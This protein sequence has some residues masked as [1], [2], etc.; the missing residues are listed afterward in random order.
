MRILITNDDGINAPGLKVLEDIAG[1]LSDDVWTVAPESDQSGL[2]HS[3]TL[4]EPLRLRALS[5][6]RFAVRG[7]PTDCVIMG[8]HNVMPALPDL[9]L[10]G[11]NAG[12]NIAGDVTYSGTVAAAMEGASLGIPSIA[13][14][15][16]YAWD[17]QEAIIPWQTARQYAPAL[18]KK[19]LAVPSPRD[20]LFNINFPDCQPDLVAGITVTVQGVMEHG[21]KVEERYDGRGNPYY[22]LVFRRHNLTYKPGSDIDALRNR[23]ISVHPVRLDLTAYDIADSLGAIIN[24]DVLLSS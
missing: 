14:S 16:A 10:S 23:Y 20:I 21:L 2:S 17:N 24:G 19:L 15:Q 11:V 22:W 7:T 13:L 3:L 5:E 8:V 4:S 6:R 1:T 9:V 18:I 12:Q